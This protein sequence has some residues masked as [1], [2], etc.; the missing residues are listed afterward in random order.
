MLKM[1][2]FDMNTRPQTLVNAQN[3]VLWHEHTP[4]DVSA[5]CSLRHQIGDTLPQ[6]MP[7]LRQTLLQFIDVMNLM[8]DANACPCM[9]LCQRRTCFI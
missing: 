3:A 9:Y 5:T 1:P 2:S 6:A 4:T 8:S 7:D